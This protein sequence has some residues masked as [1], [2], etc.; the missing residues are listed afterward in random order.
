MYHTFTSYKEMLNFV[1][2]KGI[3][4]NMSIRGSR[5]LYLNGVFSQ[6][7]IVFTQAQQ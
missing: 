6:Q 5:L 2:N 7:Y 1:L 3:E 4:L